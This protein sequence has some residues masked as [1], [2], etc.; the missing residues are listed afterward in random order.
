MCY[1]KIQEGEGPACVTECPAEALLFGKRR[2]LIEIAKERIYT[3]PETYHNQIYGEHEVGGT[4]VLH[5]AGVPFEKLGFPDL[6]NES[7]AS[8]SDGI[9]YAIYKGMVYPL[10]V[11]A[12]L[13]GS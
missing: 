6:P 7:Y 8:I 1:E 11:L 9:Q 13:V 10:V 3:D 5:L 4:Q 2:E 12:G